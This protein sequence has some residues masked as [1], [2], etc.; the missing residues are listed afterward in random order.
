MAGLVLAIRVFLA[1]MLSRRGCPGHLARRRA[2]RFS[3]GMMNFMIAADADDGASHP[4]SF[5]DAPLGAGLE[6]ILPAVVM[7]SG[8]APSGAPRNDALI[9]IGDTS[10]TG[11]RCSSVICPSGGLLTG[12][13]SPLCKNISLHPSGKSS[14]QI[15]AI[16]PHQRGVSRSSQMRWTRPR[17]ARNVMQGWSKGL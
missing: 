4:E 5:R 10:E 3:P 9:F 16:P 6:S 15:R 8:L 7:D 11:S 12:V 1:A 14:L 13:S 17:Q 2:S